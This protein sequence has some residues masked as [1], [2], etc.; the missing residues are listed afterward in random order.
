[1][2]VEEM[3]AYAMI[4]IIIAIIGGCM[5]TVDYIERTVP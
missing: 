2:Y 3:A 4:G 5:F 1:M